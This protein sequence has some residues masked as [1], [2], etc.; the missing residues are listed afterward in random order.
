MVRAPRLARWAGHAV[1]GAKRAVLNDLLAL[2]V[3]EVLLR[4]LKALVLGYY[5]GRRR[6]RH[7]GLSSRLDQ[8]CVYELWSEWV[9]GHCEIRPW[10]GGG[11]E[12]GDESCRQ[13]EYKKEVKEPPY[14]ASSTAQ[15]TVKRGQTNSNPTVTQ[16]AG[17]ASL[18]RFPCPL[19]SCLSLKWP[20]SGLKTS[21]STNINA[22]NWASRRTL[23]QMGTLFGSQTPAIRT[24]LQTLYTHPYTALRHL[25]QLTH[26]L[27]LIFFFAPR[28]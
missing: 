16:R 8:L 9:R 21:S 3:Y 26:L 7:P 5:W 12:E 11:D 28:R 13:E 17:P 25:L 10:T 24:R 22:V 1:R 18:G 23:K 27:A 20:Q 14:L 4:G 19:A 15:T 6:Q 2:R